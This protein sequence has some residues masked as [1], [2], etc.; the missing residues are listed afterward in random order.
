MAEDRRSLLKVI[1]G[2]LGGGA[3]VAVAAPVLRAV[4]DAAGRT[5]VSGAGSFVRVARLDALPEDG[6]PVGVPVIVEA[7]ID[8]WIR[9]PRT[10]IGSVW[11]E[12]DGETVRALSTI[13]PHL[14]CGIDWEAGARRFV[15][16]CHESYFEPSGEVTSGPSPRGMDPLEVRVV[17][18]HVEVKFEK[19]VL[20]TPERKR[21]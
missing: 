1:S 14:G 15:C 19:F 21:A 7:P 13:C 12:R 9:M 6:T 16:A 5:T 18:G 17:D 11:L 3:A 8:A 4:V 2:V 10:E 20:G